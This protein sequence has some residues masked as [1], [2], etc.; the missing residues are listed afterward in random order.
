MAGISPL[1]AGAGR[2]EIRFPAGYFPSGE[3][4]VPHDPLHARALLLRQGETAFAL[5]TLELP[6]VRPWALTDALRMRAAECLGVPYDR[7]WLVMT[8]D[9]AA[10]H[11]PRDPEKRALHMAALREAVAA[12]AA[13]AKARLCPVTLRRGE[14]ACGINANRDEESAEGWWVGIAGRG[15]SDKTLSLLRLD[16]PAGRPAAVLYSYAIKSSVLEDT[17][18]SDG[19]RYAS[20]DVTGLA[21]RR[22]EA[23]LGCPVLFVMG[24]AGDQVPRQKAAYLA[25]DENRHFRKVELREAGYEMLE[26]L[27]G[28]LAEALLA[29]AERATPAEAAPLLRYDHRVLV[30]PAKKPYP[31]SLPEPPVLHYDYEP[32]DPETLDIWALALGDAALIGVKPEI[33][34]PTFA[35]L[36]ARSPFPHTLLAALVN[37]GQD[38]IATDWDLEHRTYPGLHTPFQSGADRAFTEA[39]LEMLKAL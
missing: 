3:F 18:M 14:G 21:A 1:L 20:G 35:A 38:Y 16:D 6:S 19:R 25:L 29:C 31:K 7:V 26:A 33:T 32:A 5:V 8:H 15:P 37:G 30:L 9:L 39:A 13:E 24:A 12:A 36:K 34:T 23:A 28:E 17:V 27:S 22:A 10:P 4:D 2:A 11:V